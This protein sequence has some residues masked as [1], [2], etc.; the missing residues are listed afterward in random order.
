MTESAG[1]EGVLDSELVVEGTTHSSTEWLGLPG[2]VTG[3]LWWLCPPSEIGTG[4]R[5][6]QAQLV[7]S[8]RGMWVIRF[9]A[10]CVSRRFWQ[11]SPQFGEN[12]VG[13]LD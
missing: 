4:C 9:S 11:H 13:G 2:Q 8:G 12:C 6:K 5:V 3:P 1:A 10:F 7:L